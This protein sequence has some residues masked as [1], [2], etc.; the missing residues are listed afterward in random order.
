MVEANETAIAAI[1]PGLRL[2]DVDRTAKPV[3]VCDGYPT[4]SG[5]GCGRGIISY[6]GDA[7]ELRMDLRLYAD[8]TLAPGMAFSL[9]PDVHVPESAPSATATRSSSRRTAAR[10]IR[11]LCDPIYV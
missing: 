1:R 5:S 3:P 6:E 9:E 11:L 10:S 8:A 2:A 7:R 4:R